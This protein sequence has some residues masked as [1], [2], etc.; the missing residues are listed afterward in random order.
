[1]IYTYSPFSIIFASVLETCVGYIH[2]AAYT[3]QWA[4]GGAES[5][6][7]MALATKPSQLL[8][9]VFKNAR[10]MNHY[11]RDFHVDCNKTFA[12]K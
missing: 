4:S 9:K 6:A 5:T 8:H 12:T 2:K 7:D 3:S 1:M 11:Q 10:H